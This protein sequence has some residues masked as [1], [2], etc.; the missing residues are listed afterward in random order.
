MEPKELRRVFASVPGVV[1][2]IPGPPDDPAL[3]ASFV[4][5]VG[6]LLLGYPASDWLTRP[7]FWL[8]IVH[9]QDR[10]RAG[11]EIRGIFDRKAAGVSQF[12]W[13]AR[14][15]RTLWVLTFG[16]VSADQE[17][18]F[19]GMTFDITPYRLAVQRLG[20]QNSVT[21]ILAEAADLESAARSVLRAI[22]ESLE[23]EVGQL[24]SVDRDGQVLRHAGAWTAAPA[25]YAAFLEDSRG[26]TFARGVGLPGKVW[27]TQRSAWIEDVA[28][29]QDFPRAD[30]ATAAALHA[31]FAFPIT[32][33][34]S[35][36]AVVEFLSARIMQPTQE[37]LDLIDGVAGQFAQF[38]ERKR[39]EHAVADS[40]Q[41]LRQILESALD[42]VIEIDPDGI[43]TGWN[44]QAEQTFGWGREEAL[45]R[46]LSTLIIPERYRDQH[47]QGVSRAARSGEGAMIGNRIEIEARHRSGREFPVEL[48]IVA[49]PSG[50]RYSFTAFARD[51]TERRRRDQMKDDVLGFA[52]HELKSP[53][54]V[55]VGLS[56][57]LAKEVARTPTVTED[58]VDAL[59]TLSRESDRLALMVEQ[60]LDLTRMDASQMELDL[61][62][63]DVRGVLQEECAALSTRYAQATVQLAAD[64]ST[65]I[66][67]DESRLRQVVVNLLNNAAKYGGRQP[68]ITASLERQAE[69]V[70]IVVADNGPGIGSDDLPHIFERFYRGANQAQK[71]LGIGLYLTKAIV[72]QLGGSIT[73]A[74][75]PEGGACFTVT[76]PAAE[77]R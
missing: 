30:E 25:D 50:G 16:N 57:W 23:W 61:G 48:T 59:E 3:C 41:R 6:E 42:A 37:L 9:P 75:R 29:E 76:L 15:G 55:V 17:P 67:S 14:D 73:A 22:G 49:A 71:G 12:R 51:I 11:R 66:E 65:V 58:T 63:V 2:D 32:L 31:A 44:P 1:W 77:P 7:G 36:I 64:E 18:H 45:D 54:T 5:H 38:A 62:V 46:R 26:R 19:R 70:V 27:D 40:E 69:C 56:K 52:S 74:N 34:G 35:P 28:R 60:I 21:A 24:W 68:A 4:S 8:S 72:E 53:L 33:R 20:V 47:E 39:V 43:V 13:V 10:E